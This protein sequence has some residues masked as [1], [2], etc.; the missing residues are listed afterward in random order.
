MASRDWQQ[1]REVV[2]QRKSRVT[3]GITLYTH[4]QRMWNTLQRV[5][6][7]WRLDGVGGS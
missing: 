3:H 4:H 5:V 6:A 2:E 1:W 7:G